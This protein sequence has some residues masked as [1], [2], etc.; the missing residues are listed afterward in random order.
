VQK[1]HST[2]S[3]PS[4]LVR[5]VSDDEKEKRNRISS[6]MNSIDLFLL[7]SWD[8]DVTQYSFEVLL[9]LFVLT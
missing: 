6:L 5:E 9:S 8:F 7:D 3:L 2:G 4:A 1:T